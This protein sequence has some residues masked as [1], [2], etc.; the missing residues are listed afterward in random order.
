MKKNWLLGLI[1][2]VSVVLT[3]ILYPRLPAVMATHWNFQGTPDGYSPKYVAAFMG[4]LLPLGFYFLLNALPYLDPKK[5]EAYDKFQGTYSLIKNYLILFFL[6]MHWLVILSALG[7]P[8]QISV[9]VPGA[10]GLLLI[11]FGNHL[12]QIKPNY[13]VGIKTPWTLASEEVWH[14]THRLAAPLWVVGG[15]VCFIS[16]FLPKS[17]MGW[18]FFGSI[19]VVALYPVI[20]SYWLYKKKEE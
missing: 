4:L 14:K 19:L 13:F 15:I 2:L 16:V 3:V 7:Y 9:F 20:Y 17:L 11:L 6:L 10:V 12:G 5:K 18:V 8:I 1:Y